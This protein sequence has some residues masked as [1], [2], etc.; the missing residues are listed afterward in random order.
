MGRERR[1][2]IDN[3]MIVVHEIFDAHDGLPRASRRA[4]ESGAGGQAHSTALRTS[5]TLV[6]IRS[7]PL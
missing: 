4:R 6:S 2:R 1:V 5:P 7:I 3:E